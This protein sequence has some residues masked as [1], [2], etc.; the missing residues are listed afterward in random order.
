MTEAAIWWIRRDLRLQDHPAL[1]AAAETGEV[2]PVF[3]LD[4]ALLAPSGEPRRTFL[5]RALTALDQQLR[6]FGPGLVI[7]HGD[8]VEV[9]PALAT[10]VE[11]R[12]VHISAD[13][14]PY[15][16]QRDAAVRTALGDVPLVATGSPYAVA[17]GRVLTQSGR[18]FQVFTPFYRAWLQH[19]WRA[20]AE[21]E[22]DRIAWR[23][24]PSLP[25]PEPDPDLALPD[26]SEAGALR[27]WHEFHEQGLADY[28][29]R[30]DRPD[31]AGT[32]RLSVYLRWGLLHPRTLLAE[33]GPDDDVF[34]KELAWREFY[35]AVLAAWPASARSYFRPELAGLPYVDGDLRRQRLEAWKDG[36]TGY[37]IVDAA[38][39]QLQHTGWMHNR[40]RMIV[41]SFLVKDLQVEWQF[42]ARHF[43]QLLVDGDLASN[44]HGW[45][46]AAGSG[47]DAAP[48]FRIFNPTSQGKRYDPDGDFVRSWIPELAHLPGSGVHEPWA[49][50]DG[51]THGYP[52]QIVDHA[53]QRTAALEAYA[54]LRA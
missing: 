12:S 1:L 19:G 35:A 39:R 28:P 54:A 30:R 49:A 37:P 14:G 21:C 2:I 45:Q 29:T 13:Y 9:I 41:A 33:L 23:G 22:P 51:Y 31:L 40:L 34:R 5:A 7:R 8:P 6:E 15:G 36:R 50:P 47:T 44:Q 52:I 48:Y 43:M 27:A 26:A 25:L 46:W 10:E 32:S 4:D 24:A 11:A 38:M 20:P 3:V 16:T 53:E 42:G 18:P 17:P